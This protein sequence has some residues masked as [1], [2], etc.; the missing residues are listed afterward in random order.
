L[1]L[2][3][4]AKL[5]L[6]GAK[7]NY[8][9]IGGQSSYVYDPSLNTRKKEW[10]SIN[11]SGAEYSLQAN[12]GCKGDLLFG[13]SDILA[14]WISD[15]KVSDPPFVAGEKVLPNPQ[16]YEQLAKA[17]AEMGRKKEAEDIL[18]AKFDRRTDELPWSWEKGI[19]WVSWLLVN[20]GLSNEQAFFWWLGLVGLGA[21]VRLATLNILRQRSKKLHL[22][23]GETTAKR[24]SMRET[25]ADALTMGP[26]SRA[27][28]AARD[29]LMYSLTRA[30]PIIDELHRADATFN[31]MPY[32]NRRNDPVW[33]DIYFVFHKLA[34]FV[35]VSFAIAG[36]S[37]LIK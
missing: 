6:A 7:F 21:S 26:W 32:A 29:A 19:L 16:A 2:G 27:R 1:G 15:P 37:G 14:R 28:N 25:I 10:A 13:D 36:M 20:Y 12:L 30:I 22:P 34:A 5:I 24:F 17:L 33:D 35:L 9:A 23:V 3:Q 8:P 18:K 4:N 31:R 11:V